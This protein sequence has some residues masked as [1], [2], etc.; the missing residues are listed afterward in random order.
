MRYA[1]R[2]IIL[3]FLSVRHVVALYIFI[4]PQVVDNRQHE[5]KYINKT[6]IITKLINSSSILAINV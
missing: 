5:K 3:S 6:K 4:S 2:D 1:E